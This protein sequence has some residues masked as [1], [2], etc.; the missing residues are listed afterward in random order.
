MALAVQIKEA[1][2]RLGKAMV[3]ARAAVPPTT[4]ATQEQHNKF[5]ELTQVAAS[6]GTEIQNLQAQEQLE[7]L[8]ALAAGPL[9]PPVTEIPNQLGNPRA[10]TSVA[11]QPE[12]LADAQRLQ[13]AGQPLS[14]AEHLRRFGITR[15]AHV[16]GLRAYLHSNGATP[17]EAKADAVR[18]IKAAMGASGPT[19]AHLHSITDDTLGGFTVG[20]DFRAQ[21]IRALPGFSV[22]RASGARVV[23]TSKPSISYPVLNRAA[24]NPKIYTS[25]LNQ[26][27]SNWRGEGATSGGTARTPQNKPT[28]G[29][30][31]IPVHI[32]QPDPIE[33]TQQLLED[34]DVDLEGLLADLISETLGFDSDLGF[35]RGD[36]VN[37]PEGLL[38]SGAPTFTVGSAAKFTTPSAGDNGYSYGRIAGMFTGLAAQYRQR[39]KWYL[40]SKTLGDLISLGTGASGGDQHPLFPVNQTPGTLLN[41]PMYFTEFLDDGN[42]IGNTPILFGDPSYYII[43]ERRALGIIRLVERYAPNVALQPTARVG[44]Q[45]VLKEAFRLGV[46]G[47]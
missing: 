38:N 13:R 8:D 9:T 34:T 33:I 28:F 19:E 25:D 40:N 17:R 27:L 42:T 30:E 4:G 29:L 26:G 46:T 31:E 1:Q 35:L 2:E 41:R 11:V 21:V 23:Q 6:I 5:K 20:D 44:G 7:S 45:L 16:A 32:W 12:M 3:A 18:A 22:V 37:N 14:A 43:A 47:A 10:P 36:G 15:E 24:V 39:A